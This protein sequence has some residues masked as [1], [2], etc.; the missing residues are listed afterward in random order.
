MFFLYDENSHSFSPFS[1]SPNEVPDTM[2]PLFPDC[3]QPKIKKT[4]AFKQYFTPATL[5]YE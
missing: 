5:K 3:T 1:P 2:N 4:I